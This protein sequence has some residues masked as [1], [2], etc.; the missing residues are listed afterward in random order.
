MLSPEY[1]YGLPDTVLDYFLDAEQEIIRMMAGRIARHGY[2]TRTVE[3][4]LLRLQDM[5]A[6]QKDILRE[7]EKATRLSQRELVRMFNEAATETLRS[8]D[9]LYKAAGYTPVPLWDNPAMQSLIRA[10]LAKTSGEFFNLTRTTANT[11]TRQFERMLDRAY[12]NITNGGFT[13][14]EA[15]KQGIQGLTRKGIASITYPSGKTDYLDVAFRRATLTGVN[16]T[17]LQL[18]EFRLNEL[19]HDLVETTAHMGARPDHAVW[20]GR[21]FSYSGTHSKYPAFKS[22]TGYGTGAG[23]GG[24]NCRHGWY[25]FFE[26]LS[27]RAYTD[28]GLDAYKNK[29]VSFGGKKMPLYDALQHQRYIERQIRH[30]KREGAGLDAAGQDDT[31]AKHK[32]SEWQK[33]QRDFLKQTGLKRDYFRERAGKQNE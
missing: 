10:G 12:M 15:I 13:Y 6:L 29:T 27:K 31:R 2:V 28:A 24:W 18:Q 16:Q 7:L 21:V 26:G 9:A 4:Q 19:G 33:R 17:A 11:A 30:W 22:S 25:P 23:L 3:N 8:D 32:V 5:G 14:Q 1:L 20:Q